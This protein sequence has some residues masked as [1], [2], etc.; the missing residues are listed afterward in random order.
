MSSS[1]LDFARNF[2][3]RARRTSS[4][5]AQFAF[6]DAHAR[7][8]GFADPAGH[9]VIAGV[10]AEAIE[11]ASDDAATSVGGV[12]ARDHTGAPAECPGPSA[13][14]QVWIADRWLAA[15]SFERESLRTGE[16]LAGPAILV[17]HGSTGWIEPGWS[18]EVQA[19]GRLLRPGVPGHVGERLLGDIV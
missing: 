2:L 4:G 15:P 6:A 5:N 18:A 1:H 12:A 9:L 14:V 13:T 10:S 16:V 17:E 19:D 8:F 3:A 7:L 11:R